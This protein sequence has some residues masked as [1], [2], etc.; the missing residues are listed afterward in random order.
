MKHDNL[1]PDLDLLQDHPPN[2]ENHFH[3]LRERRLHLTVILPVVPPPM[4]I[5]M[6]KFILFGILLSRLKKRL[7]TQIWFLKD[8]VIAYLWTSMCIGEDLNFK[9]SKRSQKR[10]ELSSKMQTMR[11]CARDWWWFNVHVCATWAFVM[12]SLSFR[13]KTAIQSL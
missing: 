7:S 12:M 5:S 4:K 11:A 6:N 13:I 1:R 10:A 3:H 8:V 9:L 2:K